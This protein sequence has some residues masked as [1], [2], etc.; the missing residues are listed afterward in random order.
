MKKMNNRTGLLFDAPSLKREA[1]LTRFRDLGLGTNL[2][3]NG[4]T[5]VFDKKQKDVIVGALKEAIDYMA[6]AA[7]ELI[8]CGQY[9]ASDEIADLYDKLGKIRKDIS[10][11]PLD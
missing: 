9:D 3:N 11:W 1:V 8:E 10:S 4:G 2:K 6:T 5:A 7:L